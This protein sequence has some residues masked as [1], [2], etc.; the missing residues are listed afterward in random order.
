MVESIDNTLK[1]LYVTLHV[2]VSITIYYQLYK[3]TSQ[4]SLV[5]APWEHWCPLSWTSTSLEM[6]LNSS[7]S[8]SNEFWISL[9]LS[10]EV[11]HT[12]CV[13]IGC[14][15]LISHIHVHALHYLRIRS[16]SKMALWSVTF[17]WAP[18]TQW[19]ILLGNAVWKFDFIIDNRLILTVRRFGC[20][21]EKI[22]KKEE[23]EWT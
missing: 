15:S 20:Q 17:F 18:Q 5:T 12:D 19:F 14:S 4:V 23:P 8:L 16:R 2:W 9:A 13:V 7:Y 11:N 10:R 3:V 1:W 21:N 22:W 6:H